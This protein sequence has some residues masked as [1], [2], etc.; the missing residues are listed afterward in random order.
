MES[1]MWRFAIVGFVVVVLGGGGLAQAPP[2]PQKEH[3]WL[4]Q[5][6]GEWE[7]ETEA[8]LEPGKPPVKVRGTESVRTVGGLWII[9]EHKATLLDQPFTGILTLGF[10]V[11][12]KLYVGTWHDSMHSHLL[13]YEGTLDA[14]AKS[15]TILTEGPNP[16]APAKRSKFKE[17]IEVKDKDQKVL[18]TSMQGEDGKWTE[19]MTIKYQRKK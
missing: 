1:N 19:V 15:L 11:E 12:K 2:G 5:L 3:D 10:D 4:K 18:T 17:V 6:A 16:M 9:S 7:Y 8:A 13:H 14:A